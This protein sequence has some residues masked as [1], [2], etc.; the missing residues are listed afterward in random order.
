MPSAI[1]LERFAPGRLDGFVVIDGNYNP[2]A[3]ARGE[4]RKVDLQC[5]D[6]HR[7]FPETQILYLRQ[8]SRDIVMRPP[9]THDCNLGYRVNNQSFS[10]NIY[11]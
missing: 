4:R 9:L 10:E 3:K 8:R 1:A 5:D 6:C 7:G 2:A 11:M